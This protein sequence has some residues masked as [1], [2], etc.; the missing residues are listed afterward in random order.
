MISLQ[1][2]WHLARATFKQPHLSFGLCHVCQR[3]QGGIICSD[4]MRQWHH[5]VPRCLRC[6]IDL[7]SN[8]PGDTCQSCEDQSPELDRTIAA[9]HYAQ[10]WSDVLALLKF[11]EGCALAK[12]FGR[13]LADAVSARPYDVSLIMPSPCPVNG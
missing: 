9:L 13:L 10:P 11:R 4:C 12:P 7:P 3:W 6:A 8:A 1:R 5:S 2:A